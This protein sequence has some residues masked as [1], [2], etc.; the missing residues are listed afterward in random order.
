MLALH[1]SESERAKWLSSLTRAERNRLAYDWDNFWSRP[2]QREPLGQWR[3][4]LIL[5]GRGFGKTLTGAQWVRKRVNAG[6]RRIAIVGRTVAD[7]RD[8][9]I[10]GESGILAISPPSERPVYVPSKRLLIWPN[11]AEALTYSAEKPDQLRGPNTDTVWADELAAWKYPDAWNQVTFTLRSTQSGLL[12]RACI[13]TTPRPTKLIRSIRERQ[14]AHVTPGSTFENAGNLDPGYLADLRELYEGTRLGRQ[15]LYA[16]ILDDA[17][18]A[19]WT[20]DRIDHLRVKDV[21]KLRSIVI[22]IDPA[23]TSGEFSNE[24][25]ILVVGLGVDGHGYVLDDLS[26][27]HSP[28]AWAKLAIRTYE[29]QEANR[30]VAEV[31]QGGDLVKSV[32]STAARELEVTVHVTLVHAAKGKRTRAE[33]VAALYEQGRVHHVGTFAKLEDQ[34]CT[35]EPDVVIADGPQ[36]KIQRSDSPDRLDALVWALTDLMVR[37]NPKPH[38]G[39]PMMGAGP[40]SFEDRRMF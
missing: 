23:V 38:A 37:R 34:L 19:L 16:E 3:Y 21:P 18:G 15:E 26:G 29:S 11:G 7:V 20:H 24:T 39:V 35:W 2:K 5:A 8:T 36:K 40:V 27:R 9:M 25:G 1:Q 33:P 30:L 10:R 32:I 12:P 14:N 13:T 17:P 4:W 22:A 6:A 28:D 31:N